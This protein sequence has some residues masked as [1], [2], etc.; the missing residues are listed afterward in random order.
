MCDGRL[1]R[2]RNKYPIQNLPLLACNTGKS[3]LTKFNWILKEVGLDACCL[4]R[5]GVDGGSVYAQVW[6]RRVLALP[7]ADLPEAEWHGAQ[8]QRGC[9][10]AVRNNLPVCGDAAE[11]PCQE[12]RNS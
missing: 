10:Q 2:P 5:Y 6:T 12:D 7:G 9:W 4:L 8:V 1:D 11:Q 3:G